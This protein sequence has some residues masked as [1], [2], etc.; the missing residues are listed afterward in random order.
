MY[1]KII[2]MLCIT[3]KMPLNLIDVVCADARRQIESALEIANSHGESSHNDLF[4]KDINARREEYKS[5]WLDYMVA[6]MCNFSMD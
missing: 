6:N 1:D 3:G 2:D 5:D 4:Y